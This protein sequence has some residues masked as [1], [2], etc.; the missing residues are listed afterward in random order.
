MRELGCL[1]SGLVAVADNGD[2]LKSDSSVILV[3]F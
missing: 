2:L 3:A 1:L